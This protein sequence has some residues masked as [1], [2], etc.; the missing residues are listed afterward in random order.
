MLQKRRQYGREFKLRVIE[1]SYEVENIKYLS[2]ELEIRP[3][4]IYRWRSELSS[5]AQKSLPGNGKKAL[6]DEQK[7]VAR[8]QKEL[9]DVK[10]EHEILKKPSASF[11][12]KAGKISVHKEPSASIFR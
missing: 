6:T 2:A 3:E 12:R 7:E 5:E 9:A 8:L 10:L 11:P 4:L 1:Y